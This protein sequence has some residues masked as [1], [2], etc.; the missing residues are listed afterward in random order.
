MNEGALHPNNHQR[1]TVNQIYG[2]TMLS[3]SVYQPGTELHLPE[4]NE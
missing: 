2:K 4:Y 3:K 1:K